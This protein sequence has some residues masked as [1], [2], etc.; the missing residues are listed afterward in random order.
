M[1]EAD[2]DPHQLRSSYISCFL[3]LPHLI[4]WVAAEQA[5]KGKH[6]TVHQAQVR[7]A[8]QPD[9]GRHNPRCS[10]GILRGAVLLGQGPGAVGRTL[11]H[12]NI[13]HL[14]R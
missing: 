8:E 10:Q 11:H 14:Q 9:Q 4:A 6:R 1:F 3:A 2:C 13:L 12:L 5:V 7:T